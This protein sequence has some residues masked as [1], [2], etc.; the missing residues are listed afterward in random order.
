MAN[1]GDMEQV[2]D[3]SF[4][5][6]LEAEQATYFYS[7]VAEHL[8]RLEEDH[9]LFELIEEGYLAQQVRHHGDFEH[10]ART[11][12][13]FVAPAAAR[14]DAPEAFLRA[15]ATAL[16]IRKASSSLASDEML[17]A[18]CRGRRVDLAEDAASR[19][20]VGVGRG[21]AYAVLA[22][23]VETAPARRQWLRLAREA[24][25]SWLAESVSAS[26]PSDGSEDAA[27]ILRWVGPEIGSDALLTAEDPSYLHAAS[28]TAWVERRLDDRGLDALRHH[29]AAC[30]QEDFQGAA[31]GLG[32]RWREMTTAERDRL[33]T[34]LNAGFR[35]HEEFAWWLFVAC[36]EQ[37][38]DGPISSIEQA[39][40]WRATGAE[41]AP[42]PPADFVLARP[43][44]FGR[45]GPARSERWA[46]GDPEMA[47]AL[48][49]AKLTTSP[50]PPAWSRALE[51]LE[52]LGDATHVS[53]VSRLALTAAD[54]DPAWARQALERLGTV[55]W[56]VAPVDALALYFD[57][58][59]AV[60]LDRLPDTLWSRLA[61]QVDPERLVG[62][63][64]RLR[65][66]ATLVE[67]VQ[68]VEEYA[69]LLAQSEAEAFRLRRRVVERLL[70]RGARRGGVFRELI[71]H[72]R[73][74]LL[75]DEWRELARVLA[76]RLARHGAWDAVRTLLPDLPPA[77]RL[78]ATLRLPG[79][80]EEQE[81][82]PLA[83]YATVADPGAVLDEWR[84]LGPLVAEPRPV[85]EIVEH[86]GVD[87]RVESIRHMA[88][89]RLIHHRIAYEEKRWP[90]RA[91]RRAVLDGVARAL[92]VSS[93]A[94]LADLTPWL[95][96]TAA[97]QGDR[98]ARLETREALLGLVELESVSW[99]ARVEAFE[100]L[101]IAAF[102]RWH[103]A[104]ATGCRAAARSL[105]SVLSVLGR[106][107]RSRGTF[108]ERHALVDAAWPVW[109]LAVALDELSAGE[110]IV[111]GPFRRDILSAVARWLGPDG[112]D[113]RVVPAWADVVAACE[114]DVA[115]RL[116]LAESP[117][118]DEL[119]A[120]L[121][122]LLA[123]HRPSRA[124]HLVQRIAPGP[125]RDWAVRGLLRLGRGSAEERDAWSFSASKSGLGVAWRVAADAARSLPP[126]WQAWRELLQAGAPPPCAPWLEPVVHGL[127]LEP[128]GRQ[129]LMSAVCGALHRPT[130]EVETA[131][132]WWLHAAV[133]PS[134]G[135]VEP[136]D[137]ASWRRLGEA[138]ER[139]R[140]LTR[141][142]D[143]AAPAERG[144]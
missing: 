98:R 27:A 63:A 121:A 13:S 10:A 91:D 7:H 129:E 102:H 26:D 105:R 120:A 90:R 50:S 62:I 61:D 21:R 11:V 139:S 127:W 15:V 55:E 82:D 89:L 18:L 2:G 138:L 126:S 133:A 73:K 32:A 110:P 144:Y 60:W 41:S 43:R 104:A 137:R 118:A 77:E 48:A 28:A 31:A 30:R 22:R 78:L 86:L 29:L 57:A 116:V 108:E 23:L 130:E 40:G 36:A 112:P 17:A 93:D 115:Q 95:V 39:D 109:P 135:E 44:V 12:E 34:W 76:E 124:A 85:D 59:A 65:H 51:A 54:H 71:D 106:L 64:G 38:L 94:R 67:M 35:R 74:S 114:T 141:R 52:A 14:A 1:H 100:R 81:V 142:A 75:A 53:A 8:F 107:P 132:R 9:D 66:P 134:L 117:V 119:G 5:P 70:E 3:V 72:A 19:S 123:A 25:E 16:Q 128:G 97:L 101:L 33:A 113:D 92:T 46:A 79:G 111:P 122:V 84:A 42:P 136:R 140:E 87:V 56:R 96:E 49:L 20:P 47:F 99:Q 45:L 69:L 37:E 68:R 103:G 143:E 24:L 83:L 58:V 80:I 125:M 88:L 131:L 4:D 6:D